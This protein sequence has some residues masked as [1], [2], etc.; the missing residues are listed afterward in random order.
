MARHSSFTQEVADIICERIAG[1]ES[2][3]SIC[4]DE[5]MPGTSTVIK[6]LAN[7]SLANFRA[8]YTRARE[9]QADF[10]A[11]DILAIADDG[12]NDTYVDDEGNQRTD[13]DVIARS[14]LRVEARKWLAGKMAP[15]K[16]GDKI[17]AEMSGPN[18]GPVETVTRVVLV[19]MDGNSED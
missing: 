2:L 18:G 4:R 8:Q 7:D 16:Y 1:G 13:H 9:A 5:E 14:K 12:L 17:T 10:M 11:E 6:W 15:K 19:D 3:R